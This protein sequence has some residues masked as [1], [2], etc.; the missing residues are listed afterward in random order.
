MAKGFAISIVDFHHC[1]CG[2]LNKHP[3][4]RSHQRYCTKRL[5]HHNWIESVIEPQSILRYCNL[6]SRAAQTCTRPPQELQ[7]YRHRPILLSGPVRTLGKSTVVQR[8][9]RLKYQVAN[10]ARRARGSSAQNQFCTVRSL[11]GICDIN[12]SFSVTRCTRR[13]VPRD[14][15][16]SHS[17]AWRSSPANR[18]L[19]P[20]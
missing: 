12:T 5:T 9:Q 17:H 20:V 18:S 2:V 14:F 10:E 15:R 19:D 3:P 16:P 11:S 8:C 13:P 7:R 4:A 1:S 6:Q